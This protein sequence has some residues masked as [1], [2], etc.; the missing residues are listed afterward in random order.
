MPDESSPSSG[1]TPTGGPFAD[2]KTAAV[3]VRMPLTSIAEFEACVAVQNDVWG[4]AEPGHTVPSSLLLAASHIGALTIGA[5]DGVGA[6]LGFVFGLT[7]VKEGVLV[8]W[9]HLLA[10]REP[11]RGQG[12]GRLLKE[13]QRTELAR[14]GIECIYWTFDPLQARNAHLNFNRLGVR[15]VDYVVD[16]YGISG[17]PLHGGLSTDRLV[18]MSA[19]APQRSCHAAPAESAMDRV[20]ILTPFPGSR[21]VSTG[22]AKAERGMLLIEVPSNLQEVIDTAPDMAAE[23]RAATRT[24]FRWALQRG[25]DVIQFRRDPISGRSFYVAVKTPPPESS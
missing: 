23:W 17:S 24:N 14:R 5:F 2:P 16:M 1:L 10:V 22:D 4:P 21:D 8:H 18:V 9:S 20:P 11:A 3:E 15:V 12:I 6:M 7:G 19:T 13:S 25:Y